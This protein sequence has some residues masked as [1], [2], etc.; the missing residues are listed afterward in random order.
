VTA[1]CGNPLVIKPW[2]DFTNEPCE[3]HIEKHAG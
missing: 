1:G 2:V 3:T